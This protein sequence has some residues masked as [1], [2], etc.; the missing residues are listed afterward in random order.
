MA[1]EGRPVP[2][3]TLI[4]TV[5]G[6]ARQFGGSTLDTFINLLRN[7]V[8]APFETK[9]IHTVKGVWGIL[10]I[11]PETPHPDENVFDSYPPYALV[12]LFFCG[13]IVDPQRLILVSS[14]Q[15]P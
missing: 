2:R 7:K 14:A 13:S 15:K 1:S 8:D 10:S 12:L 11:Y 6:R 3:G 4:E 5:W 9:L